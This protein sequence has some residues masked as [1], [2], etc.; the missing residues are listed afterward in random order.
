MV[1]MGG[2]AAQVTDVTVMVKTGLSLG[3]KFAVMVG[4][5][6]SL[7]ASPNSFQSEHNCSVSQTHVG[8]SVSLKRAVPALMAAS[9][10][11]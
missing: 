2:E 6:S 1:M 7:A 5:L 8:H 11:S 4:A 9:L 10:P 3:V